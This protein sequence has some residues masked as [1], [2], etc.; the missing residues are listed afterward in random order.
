[1]NTQQ[2]LKVKPRGSDY[3]NMVNPKCAWQLEL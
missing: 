3:E 1:M 2:A